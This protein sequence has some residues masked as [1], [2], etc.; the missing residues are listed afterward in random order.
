MLSNMTEFIETPLFT[1]PCAAT[2]SDLY[3][4][5]LTDHF[6]LLLHI[7]STQTKNGRMG[8]TCCETVTRQAMY[9]SP[10]FRS[11]FFFLVALL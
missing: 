8:W 4:L 1:A 10:E 3:L 5:L 6:L 7:K 2:V 9:L 11:K